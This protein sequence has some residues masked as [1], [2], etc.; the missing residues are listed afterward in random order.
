MHFSFQIWNGR[1]LKLCNQ[2]ERLTDT[3]LYHLNDF[4]R[5]LLLCAIVGSWLV[6]FNQGSAILDESNNNILYLRIFLDYATPFTVSSLTGVLRNRNETKSNAKV[7]SGV[8]SK[9]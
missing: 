4:K 5:A 1:A 3:R 6:F 8:T 7:S 9:S 2:E